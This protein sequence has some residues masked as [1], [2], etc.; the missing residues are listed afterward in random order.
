M[1]LNKIL[2]YSLMTIGAA[3]SVKALFERWQWEENNV[4]AAIMLDWDDVQAVATRDLAGSSGEQ[5]VAGLLRR[6]KEKGATHLS[7]PEL[8]LNRLLV[9][10]NNEAF[11]IASQLIQ[12]LDKPAP[13][14]P[15][16]APCSGLS[17]RR[18]LALRR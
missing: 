9:K 4:L 3:S 17:T 12:M 8:T 7:I 13:G 16:R 10:G 11:Q 1:K 18:L 5:D 6:F 14:Q 15:L 2:S